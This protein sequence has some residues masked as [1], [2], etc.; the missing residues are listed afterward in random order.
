M[1]RCAA[2]RPAALAESWAMRA[3]T[4]LCVLPVGAVAWLT[5][6]RLSVR[7]RTRGAG[8]VIMPIYQ[9]STFR[10]VMLARS[11]GTRAR[12]GVL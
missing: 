9:T 8:S 6:A 10:Q 3:Q 4:L 5:R 12:L 7:A 2:P 1:V 11:A